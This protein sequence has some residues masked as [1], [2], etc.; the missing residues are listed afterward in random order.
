MQTIIEVIVK[1]LT[2]KAGITQSST[3]KTSHYPST[4]STG[5]HNSGEIPSVGVG[6]D[7]QKPQM[8]AEK[9]RLA[10]GSTNHRSSQLIQPHLG[11]PSQ[12]PVSGTS[13]SVSAARGL[14]RRQQECG[15]KPRSIREWESDQ[16]RAPEIQTEAKPTRHRE[17]ANN[18]Q[19]QPTGTLQPKP[20]AEPK[21]EPKVYSYARSYTPCL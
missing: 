12:K 7:S 2:D 21:A 8:A 10:V 6:S 9:A 20:K 3:T 15:F 16:Q 11:E 17:R 14:E 4:P 19:Q 1:Y 5:Q 18:D 13:L